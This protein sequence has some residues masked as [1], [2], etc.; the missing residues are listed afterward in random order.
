MYLSYHS[1]LVDSISCSFISSAPAQSAALQIGCPSEA[2]SEIPL[3]TLF[4]LF[5]LIPLPGLSWATA[6]STTST[7]IFCCQQPTTV[8]ACRPQ[9]PW[10]RPGSNI[11]MQ[12]LL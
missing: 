6:P 2:E 1:P 9:P 4:T 10:P 5:T 8:H 12:A 3:A 7:H 11:T